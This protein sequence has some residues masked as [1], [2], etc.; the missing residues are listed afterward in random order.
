V[1]LL[2]ARSKTTRAGVFSALS[3]TAAVIAAAL[4]LVG[5][6]QAA[7]GG[8]VCNVP[9][10]YATIQAAVNDPGCSTINVAP[11]AYSENV[12][13]VRTLTLNGAQAGNPVAGRTSGGPAESTVSGANPIGANPVI[14]VQAADVTIDG[15]TLKNAVTTSAAIGIAVKTAGNGALIT[16]N[17]LD[18]INTTDLGVNGTAQAVYLETG[19]DN[20]T[21]LANEM[22]N[23][24][25]VRS[26]KGVTIGDASSANPSVNALIVGNSI[27]AITSTTRGAY[28]VSLNNGNGST[29]NSGL[30]VRG[31]SISNL[32][33]GGWVH[34]VGLEANT[35]GAVVRDNSISSLTSPSSDAVAV[36]FE[37]N[38]S[39]STAQV[40]E[41]NL[42][43]TPAAYGIA[44][45]P[46]L[47]GPP[48]NGTCNWWGSATGP[49]AAGN[50]GGT[51]SKVTPGVNYQPWLIAPAPGG[52][53]FGG[54]VPTDKDQCKND[55]WQTQV[56]ADGTVFK[57]QGDC[58]QYVNTGK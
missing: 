9:T 48:L 50:P 4:M 6:T 20:V 36:W 37:A 5:S 15:F 23:V 43:V 45:H 47:S 22:K 10:D 28:G 34:A 57:N 27:S 17:I 38:P 40:N 12:V 11:G 55:G 33:G 29:A 42:A 35:P 49:T 2:A 39:F 54:N 26:A 51:G 25:S 13:I 58:I 1:P 56:R 44:V 53:C 30:E 24:Q 7:V 19:P 31:N 32:N 46:A 16:N 52:S 8:P 21:I 41:N 18:G 14:R 3:L